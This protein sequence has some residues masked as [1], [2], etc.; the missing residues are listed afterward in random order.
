MAGINRFVAFLVSFEK[1]HESR[2]AS[3][4]FAGASEETKKDKKSA[5]GS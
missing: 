5:F 1:S 4:S 2:R 3:I